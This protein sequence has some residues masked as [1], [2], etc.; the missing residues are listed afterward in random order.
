MRHILLTTALSVVLTPIAANAALVGFERTDGYIPLLDG[1]P[2][3]GTTPGGPTTAADPLTTHVGNYNAGEP[4]TTLTTT[5]AYTPNTGLWRDISGDTDYVF[6][7]NGVSIPNQR[8]QRYATAHHAVPNAGII[9][10]TGDQNFVMRAERVTSDIN[11]AYTPDSIDLGGATIADTSA[12]LVSWVIWACTFDP[13]QG[14]GDFSWTFRDTLGTF[15]IEVGIDLTTTELFYRTSENGVKIATNFA[16]DTNNYDKLSF[17]FDLLNESASLSFEDTDDEGGPDL[18]GDVF[19]DIAL[20][21]LENFGRIDWFLSAGNPKVSF[22]DS[23]FTVASAPVPLPAS[24]L[25]LIGGIAGLG[26]MRRR[27]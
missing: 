15:G 4:G 24:A 18:T 19:T 21:P 1:I 26:M 6:N 9:P 12:S 25:L 10:R 11:M 3:A 16:V 27:T 13:G 22:D 5:P 23:S 14:A 20:G 2:G 7:G 17:E 8:T